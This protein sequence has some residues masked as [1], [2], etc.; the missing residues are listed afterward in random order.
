MI[1][2]KLISEVESIVETGRDLSVRVCR[3]GGLGVDKVD[4][5]F[6][7]LFVLSR[8]WFQ[9]RRLCPGELGQEG[10]RLFSEHIE[11]S[12]LE[13]HLVLVELLPQRPR[14]SRSL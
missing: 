14:E 6:P 8:R 3:F 2:L 5:L 13:G 1:H 4:G 11:E 12:S 9:P 10:E 7:L